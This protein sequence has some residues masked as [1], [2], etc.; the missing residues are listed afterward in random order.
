MS[1]QNNTMQKLEMQ[2]NVNLSRYKNNIDGAL[3]INE[4]NMPVLGNKFNPVKRDVTTYTKKHIAERD[5]HIYEYDDTFTDDYTYDFFRIESDIIKFANEKN[6]IGIIPNKG[7]I[8]FEDA[9]YKYYP[10][11]D[12]EHPVTLLKFYRNNLTDKLAIWYSTNYAIISNGTL[13]VTLDTVNNTEIS[14]IGDTIEVIDVVTLPV[15]RNYTSASDY[16]PTT[17][18]SNIPFILCRDI[19]SNNYQLRSHNNP[20][21]VVQVF[22]QNPI[23]CSEG[24]YYLTNT[25]LKY[26][27]FRQETETIATVNPISG[28]KFNSKMSAISSN[29]D[30]DSKCKVIERNDEIN[31][32]YKSTSMKIGSVSKFKL[33]SDLSISIS[34]GVANSFMTTIEN[35]VLKDNII[36]GWFNGLSNSW[37]WMQG[38]NIILWRGVGMDSIDQNYLCRSALSNKFSDIGY[39]RLKNG[40]WVNIEVNSSKS[41]KVIFEPL[42]LNDKVYFNSKIM[43]LKNGNTTF[44]NRLMSF[45]NTFGFTS[46]SSTLSQQVYISNEDWAS[47]AKYW[48]LGNK[49]NLDENPLV[50]QLAP[51][52]SCGVEEI[53]E[54]VKDKRWPYFYCQ[55]SIDDA[56]L[57]NYKD[58]IYVAPTDGD[59]QMNLLPTDKIVL[60]SPSGIIIERIDGTKAELLRYNN[61]YYPIYMYSTITENIE[62]AFNCQGQSYNI[63][64]GVVYDDNG[65]GIVDV[66]D[67]KYLGCNGFIALF[68]NE[69]N[70]TIYQF[71]ADNT[72]SVLCES[73]TI[74]NIENIDISHTNDEIYLSIENFDHEHYTLVIDSDGSS[75]KIFDNEI[76]SLFI[77]SKGVYVYHSGNWILCELLSSDEEM[78]FQNNYIETNYYGTDEFKLMNV[79]RIYLRF[80]PTVERGYLNNVT[81]N[82]SML[83][84]DGEIGEQYKID[85]STE[86]HRIAPKQKQCLGIKVRLDN[87]VNYTL[88]AMSIGITDDSNVVTDNANDRNNGLDVSLFD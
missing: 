87:L 66:S 82:L 61:K 32:W 20:T 69:R 7:I 33:Y 51:V 88:S 3:K 60:S 65:N 46:V 83:T 47:K 59:F 21:G 18:Y 27:A 30:A 29:L 6:A 63:S 74:K 11:S 75:Y 13:C 14:Y 57:Y 78:T 86:I 48:A 52:L 85:P 44:V 24:V 41:D 15:I 79:D 84:L 76:D 54:G 37:E 8:C 71:T 77:G 16:T 22:A 36:R 25:E 80:V 53:L 70:K 4:T 28:S 34:S 56:T 72:L 23:V 39:M 67:A 81:V 2:S 62:Y 68:F 35:N 12:K 55:K 50:Y 31:G 5:G 1:N 43:T 45:P 9:Y 40:K 10:I 58:D 26:F 42:L 49:S 19:D 38:C 17:N 64:G 73:D